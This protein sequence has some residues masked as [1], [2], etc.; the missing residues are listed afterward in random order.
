MA[1]EAPM[2]KR[3]LVLLSSGLLAAASS[4]SH[5]RAYCDAARE[6]YALFQCSDLAYFQPLP[7]LHVG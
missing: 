7:P 2:T 1:T 6:A 4:T 3:L 5:L